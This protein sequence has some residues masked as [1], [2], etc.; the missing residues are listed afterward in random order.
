MFQLK[1]ELQAETFDLINECFSGGILC[2]YIKEG[3]P[4]CFANDA[5]INMLGYSR[6]EFEESFKDATTHLNFIQDS[7]LM[8]EVSVAGGGPGT[9]V[10]NDEIHG[11]IE[12][13]RVD[14]CDHPVSA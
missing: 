3:Y 7:A 4:L 5:F 13:R 9:E 10:L 8:R 11:A 2:T 6:A 1:K 12:R 14:G